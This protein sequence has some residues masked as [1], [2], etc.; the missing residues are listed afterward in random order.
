MRY[1]GQASD[2]HATSCVAAVILLVI[3]FIKL[4]TAL[5]VQKKGEESLVADG[6]AVALHYVRGGAI[7][8]DL[9]TVAPTMVQVGCNH[10]TLHLS[11]PACPHALCCD[12]T[13][14]CLDIDCRPS[15]D[16]RHFQVIL[17]TI[18]KVPGGHRH[19]MAADIHMTGL[20]AVAQVACLLV[21]SFGGPVAA[22]RLCTA[23]QWLSVLRLV[24]LPRAFSI[25]KASLLPHSPRLDAC[26]P[27]RGRA[28]L[29]WMCS[30]TYSKRLQTDCLSLCRNSAGC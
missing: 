29:A 15:V 9:L 16:L 11:H 24:R 25:V 1:P 22:A 21:G 12:V 7:F 18:C 19:A 27:A 4:N 26:G 3:V 17:E 10:H 13:L 5:I 2:S 6:H 23:E 20:I 8:T 30:T 14:L 28:R